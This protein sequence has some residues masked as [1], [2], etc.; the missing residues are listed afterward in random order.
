MKEENIKW[1]F[2]L[3]N[4]EGVLSRAGL[5]RRTHL[6]PTTISALVDELVRERLVVETGTAKVPKSGRRAINLC[7]KSNGRQLVVFSLNR[8]G[9]RYTLFDLKYTVLE[10]CF[11][12][13]D[14]DRYGGFAEG[15]SRVEPD[16]GEDYSKL[17]EDILRNRAPLFDVSYAAGILIAFP[18]IFAENQTTLSLSAMRV[19][20]RAE[21]L[22][23]LEKR[24]G[25]PL[26]VGN[27]SMCMAY[28]EK[29]HFD[30]IGSEVLD[31]IYV[32]VGDG[33]GAGIICNGDI[34]T[35]VSNT[36]GEIGH[37]SIDYRGKPCSC[38]N[39]GCLE[40]Y[41]STE[42]ILSRIKAVAAKKQCAALLD[43]AYDRYD[44]VTLEMVSELYARGEQMIC[45]ELED[46]AAQL[47]CGIHSLVSITGI[48]RIV[49][50]GGIERL[51]EK[52]LNSLAEHARHGGL[53]MAEATFSFAESGFRGD[54]LGIAQYFVDKA[55]HIT[56]G[57][58]DAGL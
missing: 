38:G 2:N 14:A 35:G 57:Y 7:I 46:V 34:F 23:D 20:I 22:Q 36:A 8:W 30:Q 15:A 37:V 28:A 26:F 13:H 24:L 50:G 17:I 33:V 47:L 12:A 48:Q 10:T 16:S 40:Q 1:V 42:A 25:V 18:G 27:S 39:R 11:V 5:V 3:I 21:V 49:L 53:L 55:M 44:N 54:S 31:L 6:S 9:V 19:S 29:K 56:S 4:R 51:E 32:N 45:E 41:A 43:L 52:F 58:A